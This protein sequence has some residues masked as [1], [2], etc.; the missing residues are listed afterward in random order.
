MWFDGEDLEDSEDEDYASVFWRRGQRYRVV[1]GCEHEAWPECPECGQPFWFW[2]KERTLR[3][4]DGYLRR[5]CDK[6]KKRGVPVRPKQAPKPKRGQSKL[7]AAEPKVA[8]SKCGQSKLKSTKPKVAKSKRKHR[9]EPPGSALLAQLRR[10]NRERRAELKKE[11]E[12]RKAR[13]AAAATASSGA[14]PELTAPPGGVLNLATAA[15]SE[16]R[17][18]PAWLD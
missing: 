15:P 18:S 13:A 5:R 1:G 10:E 11:A 6:H 3:K 8:K 9:H 2:V 4:S 12:V 16:T 17:G 14:A 7:K